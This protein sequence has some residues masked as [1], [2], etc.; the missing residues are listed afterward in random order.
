[1]N[2]AISEIR[3]RSEGIFFDEK[4]DIN[5]KLLERNSNI[6][7]V[8]NV[9][10][11]GNV[12]FEND[13]YVLNY[14]IEYTL[15]LPSTRSMEPVDITQAEQVTELFV[16]L[17]NFAE[18]SDLVEANLV[19]VLETNF[20]DLEESVIDNILLSIPMRVLTISE[21]ESDELPSGDR[22]SVLTEQQ[23]QKLQEEKKQE[24]N[25]FANLDGLFED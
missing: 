23:Y 25:P 3:K 12:S 24:N 6:L 16:D 22:W 17:V 19:L 21:S 13:L 14:T 9:Q 2:L 4:L 18:K 7:D 10:V 5:K 15:T 1:M 20:I 8:K 11:Q